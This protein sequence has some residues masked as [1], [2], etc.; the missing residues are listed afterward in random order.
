M[1]VMNSN[2]MHASLQIQSGYSQK[3][4]SKRRGFFSLVGDYNTSELNDSATG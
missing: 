4:N 3:L 1:R 2:S